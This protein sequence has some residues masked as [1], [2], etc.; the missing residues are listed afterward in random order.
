MVTRYAHVWIASAIVAGALGITNGSIHA[1]NL[2]R[3]PS[4]DLAVKGFS[5]KTVQPYPASNWTPYTFKDGRT[6]RYTGEVEDSSGFA[7]SVLV[8][9]GNDRQVHFA[10]PAVNPRD[11]KITRTDQ[12]TMAWNEV[13]ADLATILEDAR[14][15]ARMHRDLEKF[16]GNQIADKAVGSMREF[17]GDL[18]RAVPAL[19]PAP[20]ATP[21]PGMLVLSTDGEKIGKVDSIDATQDGRVTAVNVATGGFLGIGAR[22]V[23]I[24]E[25]KFTVV[26]DNVRVEMTLDQV[27][28]MPSQAQ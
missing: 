8:D 9:Y 4:V 27:R 20:S 11:I 16:V 21:R 22:L 10:R 23:A 6:V 15:Q 13:A 5:P 17:A 1:Q 14:E 25:G 19:A 18:R 3:D 28:R 12:M 26:S 24:P 7:R 2:P